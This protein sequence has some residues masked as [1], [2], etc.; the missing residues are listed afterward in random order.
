MLL[1][2]AAI[3]ATCAIHTAFNAPIST[4]PPA[5]NAPIML[6][7]P[8]SGNLQLPISTPATF[9]A[10]TMSIETMIIFTQANTLQCPTHEYAKDVIQLVVSALTY[11]EGKDAATV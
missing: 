8:C 11:T 3:F 4:R 2:S 7:D 1:G 5:L 6:T 9:T 10:T